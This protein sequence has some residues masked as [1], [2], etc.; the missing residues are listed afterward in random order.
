MSYQRADFAVLRDTTYGIGFHWT[1]ATM[2]REGE[3]KPFDEA[4]AAFDVG[5]FVEQA[6]EAG[7]GHVLFTST[8]SR[9]WL[10]CPNPEVDRIVGGHTCERDLIGDLADGLAAADIR[11]IVY[12]NHNLYKHSPD[13][14]WKQAVGF[15][16]LDA[17]RVL[18]N[19]CKVIGWMGERYGP[20]IAAWWFDGGY[21]LDELPDTPWPRLTAAAKAGHPGRLVCYNPGIER[22]TLYTQC[23]DYWAG[24]VCRLNY[25]PRGKLTPSGLPWYAFVSWHGDS[26]KGGC[27]AW[28]MGEE[29]RALDWDKPSAQSVATFVRRFQAVGGTATF[30]VFCYQDGSALETDLATLREVKRLAR[31]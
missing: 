21:H 10:C 24:E 7:A 9:H 31:P 23:Q 3:P 30:N 19:W 22:H 27:G 6:V 26:R 2:P 1:T 20:R 25:I 11:L 8:H 5:A 28:V 15:E 13:T 18:D 17:P 12:Y 16:P 4:V 29:N 14:E